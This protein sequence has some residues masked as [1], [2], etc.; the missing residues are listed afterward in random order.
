VDFPTDLLREP[1]ADERDALGWIARRGPAPIRPDPGCVAEAAELLTRSRRPVLVAGRVRH[2]AAKLL[3]RFLEESGALFLAQPEARSLLPFATANAVPGAKA[4]ALAEADLI[5]TLGCQLNFQLAYGSRA[6]L[7]PTARLIRVGRSQN[8]LVD[9]RPADVEVQGDVGAALGALL[10][11]GIRPHDPDLGWREYLRAVSDERETKLKAEVTDAPAGADG[12][13]HPYRLLEA[14][15]EFVGPNDVVVADGGDILS[16]ARVAL[17]PTTYLDSGA[18][19]C[20]GVGVPFAIAAALVGGTRPVVCVTGDG[21][22][23]FHAMELDTASRTGAPVLVVVA[24]NEAWNIERTDQL[25]NW[26]GHI[27]GSELPGCRYDTLANAL[28]VH[29]DRVDDPTDLRDALKDALDHL[30]ALLDV[31]VT[32]DAESPDSRAGLPRVPDHHA[33]ATWDTA[34]RRL[35]AQSLAST[36][37]ATAS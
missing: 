9:N 7:A 37:P 34:E 3:T 1:V 27:V 4:R 35:A 33:L 23:G 24:N 21:A 20:L 5:M 22:L 26:N 18:F 12:R 32:R 19:G 30:P 8:E 36:P 31:A 28:G 10:A 17:P 6:V 29:G 14:V 2:L 11:I 25:A 13:M 16:F 15:G